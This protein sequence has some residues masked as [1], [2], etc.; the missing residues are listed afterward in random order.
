MDPFTTAAADILHCDFTIPLSLASNPS[1]LVDY[2]DTLLTWGQMSAS[3][4]Q[5]VIQAVQAQTTPELKVETAVHLIV[6]S[7]DFVVLK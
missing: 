5:I 6:E 4:R 2:L 1:T 7:P 3:T